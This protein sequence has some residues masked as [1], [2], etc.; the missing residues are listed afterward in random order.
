M[1]LS[2]AGAQNKLAVG[3]HQGRI[4]LIRGTTATSHILKPSIPDIEDSVYNEFFC[5]RLAKAMGI[6]VAHVEIYTIQD[7]PCLLVQRYDRIIGQ[8]NIT[9]RLH[10][11]DFC[12]ASGVMPELKYE[13]EGGPSLTQCQEILRHHSS[14]P[15]RNQLDLLQ[16]II[17][18]YLIANADA[19]AKN[20]SLLYQN[21]SVNLAPAYDLLSTG[22][23]SQLN[24]KMAMKIGGKYE[25]NAVLLRHWYRLVP[26]VAAAKR[27]LRQRL[28]A[29][30]RDCV[31]QAKILTEQCHREGL[32]NGVFARICNTIAARAALITQRI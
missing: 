8:D 11:E 17:F 23:Y 16:R 10:Q 31:Q 15:A 5:M 3:L 9:Q 14:Q 2:L 25:P 28:L 32:S 7:V 26:D 4:A 20:F 27:D 19:H 24:K 12:Q 29:M 18:N 13:R 1:R 30:A 6:D 21:N 22:I